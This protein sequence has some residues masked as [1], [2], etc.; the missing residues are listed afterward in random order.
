MT[1]RCGTIIL[2]CY[3]FVAPEN[4]P[5]ST[6]MSFEGNDSQVRTSL[7]DLRSQKSSPLIYYSWE[8]IL[9]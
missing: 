6:L 1:D 2:A 4:E 3:A 5:R 8:L 9:D 7:F